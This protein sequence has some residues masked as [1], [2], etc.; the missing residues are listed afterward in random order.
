MNASGTIRQSGP[1]RLNVRGCVLA[2][3]CKSTNWN[4]VN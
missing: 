4:R 2:L 1:D 3:I